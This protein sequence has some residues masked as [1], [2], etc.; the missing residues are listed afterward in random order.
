MATA[1]EDTLCT[2]LDV[3]PGKDD[4]ISDSG[5][6]FGS[7]E[8]EDLI[9]AEIL[10]IQE[11]KQ[12]AESKL[13]CQGLHKAHGLTEGVVRQAL[14]FMTNTGKVTRAFPR[15]KES[16]RLPDK[17]KSSQDESTK[18]RKVS[19]DEERIVKC[20]SELVK[21]ASA[22]NT[23][24]SD[25]IRDCEGS[26]SIYISENYDTDTESQ[27]SEITDCDFI[28]NMNEN[29][30]NIDESLWQRTNRRL[31]EVEQQIQSIESK[32]KDRECNDM[33]KFQ[34]MCDGFFKKINC[35]EQENQS[36]I[37]E[38]SS[39]KNEIIN[40]EA[41]VAKN[42]IE[43]RPRPSSQ[44]LQENV[45]NQ[46]QNKIAA[47]APYVFGINQ[48][49]PQHQYNWNEA[50]T[51]ETSTTTINPPR[52]CINNDE[53]SIIFSRGNKN[54]KEGTWKIPKVST[55][56]SPSRYTME[57]PTSNRY[58][59]L[60]DKSE[61]ELQ[62]ILNRQEFFQPIVQTTVPRE[63]SIPA[64][65]FPGEGTYAETLKRGNMT[66][67]DTRR[68][69]DR[70]NESTNVINKSRPV[71]AK[72]RSMNQQNS[73]SN[74][75]QVTNR[76]QN[77]KPRES[78]AK[79]HRKTTVILGDSMVKHIE[80]WKM[81]KALRNGE[82]IVVHSFRGATTDDMK[83]YI[84]PT[85]RR[86]PGHVVIH[87]GTNDL[88]SDKTPKEIAKDIYDIAQSLKTNDMVTINTNINTW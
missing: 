22:T 9:E 7:K 70:G 48:T 30:K 40:L 3:S 46:N 5:I 54:A 13:V 49:H 68:D 28:E 79:V 33:G 31:A 87:V 14:S 38:N 88:E 12:R 11:K 26:P 81:R 1:H 23:D 67:K 74:K 20:R 83:S 4:L 72:S 51:G 52:G 62:S 84:L 82:N 69:E 21:I 64:R 43:I 71:G 6:I 80:G 45:F 66:Q 55:V 65:N 8:I 19:Q 61:D 78:N 76:P 47:G 50:R 16:L 34:F 35:L 42:S 75:E 59:I 29:R 57:L 63:K 53:N 2:A 85:K 37:Y 56:T 73:K 36:L 86:N 60:Q 39:L 27:T 10:K 32:L 44:F 24:T 18:E 25:T 77:T 41:M 15:G 17:K 58:R